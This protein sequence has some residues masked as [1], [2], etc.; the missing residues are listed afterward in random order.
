MLK[1]E[2]FARLIVS[3]AGVDSYVA[4]A[5]NV[6][7]EIS[8]VPVLSYVGTVTR[9]VVEKFH[10]YTVPLVVVVVGGVVVELPLVPT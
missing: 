3:P 8:V 6:P 10:A 1:Y 5:C 2:P 9:S 7:F 4:A